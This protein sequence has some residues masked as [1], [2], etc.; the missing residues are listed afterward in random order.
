MTLEKHHIGM[1]STPESF[2]TVRALRMNG[3]L[4]TSEVAV[5][6]WRADNNV[7]R[8]GTDGDFPGMHDRMFAFIN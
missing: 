6:V 3:A 2:E 5:V 4:Q 8:C 7:K 1:D